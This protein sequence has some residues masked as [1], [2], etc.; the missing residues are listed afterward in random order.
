MPLQKLKQVHKDMA[1][2]QVFGYS[3][4]DIA[5][6]FKQHRDHVYRILNDPLVERYR[7]QLETIRNERL[8]N[9]NVEALQV[10]EDNMTIFANNLVNLANNPNSENARERANVNCLRFAGMNMKEKEQPVEYPE[11]K[12][13]FKGCEK[14]D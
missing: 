14:E 7:E 9:K 13:T 11:L 12:V 2:H 5:D 1:M 8:I 6:K 3:A 4:I 10:L